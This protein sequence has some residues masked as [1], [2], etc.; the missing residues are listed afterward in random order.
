MPTCRQ[1]G[2]Q[3]GTSEVGQRLGSE[4]TAPTGARPKTT[5]NRPAA[6]IP[7]TSILYPVG[8]PTGFR[9][10]TDPSPLASYAQIAD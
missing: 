2:Q 8:T 1:A 5:Q 3:L 6:Y 10:A 4:Q 7:Q 9:T